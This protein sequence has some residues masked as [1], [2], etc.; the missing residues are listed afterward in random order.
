MGRKNGRCAEMTTTPI[1][2]P[3]H[4]DVYPTLVDRGG[5]TYLEITTSLGE[6]SD[7]LAVIYPNTFLNFT[8]DYESKPLPSS[9]ISFNCSIAPILFDY[10][11]Q[12]HFGKIMLYVEKMGLHGDFPFMFSISNYN[13]KRMTPFGFYE[14]SLTMEPWKGFYLEDDDV[15]T[16]EYFAHSH[17]YGEGLTLTFL[18]LPEFQTMT[19]HP[20]S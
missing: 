12:K 15:E 20:L 19:I 3:T 8:V 6:E 18:S 10:L 4:V 16:V 9:D 7:L 2:I 17:L 11:T 1:Y 13:I 5:E 14:G